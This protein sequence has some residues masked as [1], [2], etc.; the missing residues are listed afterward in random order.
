M[1]VAEVDLVLR[2]LGIL[3]ALAYVLERARFA[4]VRL[5]WVALA[6]LWAASVYSVMLIVRDGLSLGRV[7]L[8]VLAPLFSLTLLWARR[9]LYVLMRCSDADPP[10]ADC[11]P[12][13][14][15]KLFLRASGLF[16]VNEQKRLLVNVPAVFWT[17]R[18]GDH[19]IAAKISAPSILGVGVPGDE[20]GW[21]YAF[22][23]PQ[24]VLRLAAGVLYFGPWARQALG[25]LYAR[26]MEL[27]LLY[28]TCADPLTLQR[29]ATALQSP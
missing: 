6:G 22:V 18:L 28:F 11:P 9:Q 27:K 5:R 25:L 23:E 10:L 1:E 3:L 8:V 21:W 24:Q 16:E 29:L 17:T 15:E 14:E 2:F 4:S 19:I 12:A 26:S 20:R 13:P 7:L